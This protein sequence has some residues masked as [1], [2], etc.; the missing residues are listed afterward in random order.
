MMLHNIRLL[1]S[2]NQ[3]GWWSIVLLTLVRMLQ[4]LSVGGQLVSSLVFTLENKPKDKWGLYGSYVMTAASSGTLLG[5]LVAA[6]LRASLSDDQLHSWGWRLPFLSGILVGISGL[7]LKFFCEDT[8]A[9]FIHRKGDEEISNP[10][11]V[12]FSRGN[13][14]SLVSATLV[15]MLWYVAK[16]KYLLFYFSRSNITYDRND[17]CFKK[18]GRLVFIFNLF[19]WEHLCTI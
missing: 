19:G 6:A 17:L 15:P 9:D 1:P 16:L 8:N 18:S 10:I 14:K 2:Y 12:A 4:G 5:N 13:R 3:I 7:Y 11:K